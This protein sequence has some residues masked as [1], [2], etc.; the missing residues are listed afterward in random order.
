M[1]NSMLNQ[2]LE[3]DRVPLDTGFGNMQP[4]QDALGPWEIPAQCTLEGVELLQMGRYGPICMGQLKQ[5]TTSTAV[6]IKILKG[7]QHKSIM[8]MC[9]LRIYHTITNVGYVFLFQMGQINRRLQNLWIF[10]FST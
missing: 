9:P 3:A 7:T 8:K 1:R 6:V 10:A 5:D 2:L 4:A